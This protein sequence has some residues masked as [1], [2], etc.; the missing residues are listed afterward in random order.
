MSNP[1]YGYV[2]SSIVRE[3]ASLGSDVGLLVPACVASRL[4]EHYATE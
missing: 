1:G 3:L 4:R 2:S